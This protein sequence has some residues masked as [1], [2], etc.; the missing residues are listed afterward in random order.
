[1][2]S[3]PELPVY[4]LSAV[5]ELGPILIDPDDGE[6][7]RFR[8]EIFRD[9]AADQLPFFPKVW[10]IRTFRIRPTFP[11]IGGAPATAAT[12]E[13]VLIEDNSA[14]WK[15]LRRDSTEAVLAAVR[16]ELHAHFPGGEQP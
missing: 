14:D 2:H 1:M 11:Q 10:R 4:E 7:L 16:S 9:L 3:I 8:I 5:Y 15:R 6:D 12:D 13:P